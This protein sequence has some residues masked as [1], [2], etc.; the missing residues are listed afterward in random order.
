MTGEELDIV[1]GLAHERFALFHLFLPLFGKPTKFQDRL[2]AGRPVLVLG[3]DSQLKL[4]QTTGWPG[5]ASQGSPH[6]PLPEP[7]PAQQALLVHVKAHRAA[8]SPGAPACTS[9]GKEHLQ[10]HLSFPHS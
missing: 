9:P 8:G 2:R 7:R 3:N 4:C 1:C 5:L 10:G 6:Q